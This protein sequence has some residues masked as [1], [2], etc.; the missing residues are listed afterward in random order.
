MQENNPSR[1][2]YNQKKAN[3]YKRNRR[4]DRYRSS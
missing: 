2:Q 1:D 4:D 3:C